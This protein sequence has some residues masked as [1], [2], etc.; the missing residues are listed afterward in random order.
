MAEW[1]LGLCRWRWSFFVGEREVGKEAVGIAKFLFSGEE[2][3][4]RNSVFSLVV[5]FLFLRG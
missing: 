2:G 3:S 1:R 5:D 4:S